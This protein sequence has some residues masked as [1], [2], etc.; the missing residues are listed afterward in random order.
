MWVLGSQLQILAR[1]VCP[2]LPGTGPVNKQITTL[3]QGL[4]PNHTGIRIDPRYTMLY[5]MNIDIISGCS[6]IYVGK[7]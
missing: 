2:F 4:Q 1:W 3:G 5:L 6:W 7:S